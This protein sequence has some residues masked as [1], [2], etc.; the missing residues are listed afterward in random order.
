MKS[1]PN[2]YRVPLAQWRKWRNDE[3]MVFNNL[4]AEMANQDVF[5]HP[6]AAK[7]PAYVW[8]TTRWNA[9]WRAASFMREIRLQS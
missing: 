9:A 3:R 2:K 5:S 1:V 8:K 6:K 4:Y 7:Q